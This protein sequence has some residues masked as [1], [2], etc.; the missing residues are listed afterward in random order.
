[1]EAKPLVS[2]DVKLLKKA[3]IEDTMW[4][5]KGWRDEL[6]GCSSGRGVKL[7]MSFAR[8]RPKEVWNFE[9]RGG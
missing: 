5:M 3:G 4:E 6:G 8:K 2:V 7:G 1:V 9:M